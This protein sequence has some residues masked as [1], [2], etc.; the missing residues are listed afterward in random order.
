MGGTRPG[1]VLPLIAGT[2]IQYFPFP[3][4]IVG[5]PSV[6]TGTIESIAASA[7]EL[8]ALPGV[9]S[10]DL[11]AF[12]FAGDVPALIK[13]AGSFLVAGTSI[14]QVS[15]VQRSRSIGGGSFAQSGIAG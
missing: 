12:R 5:H 1:V 3:G 2:D 14:D 11:L 13:T 6:L 15:C 8:A 10:L 7:T 9:H 4:T